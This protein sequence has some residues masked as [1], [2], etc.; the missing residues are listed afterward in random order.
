M[1]GSP[2]LR[3]SPALRNIQPLLQN[4]ALATALDLLA[5]GQVPIPWTVK[6]RNKRRV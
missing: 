4:A 5:A 2:A 6:G 1:K 3:V